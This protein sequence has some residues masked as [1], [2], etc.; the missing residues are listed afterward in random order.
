MATLYTLGKKAALFFYVL[1]HAFEKK[2]ARKNV[3]R[4]SRGTTY[5]L[6]TYNLLPTP[7]GLIQLGLAY[8]L[9]SLW[10]AYNPYVLICCS[11]ISKHVK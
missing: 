6:H 7:L 4:A 11:D 8:T 3:R 2:L 1:V 9:Y 5:G 10:L